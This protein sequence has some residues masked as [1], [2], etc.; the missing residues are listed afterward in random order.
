MTTTTF[1]PTLE[2]LNVRTVPSSGL[3]APPSGMATAQVSPLPSHPYQGNG[4]GQYILSGTVAATKFQLSGRLKLTGFGEFL[5]DGWVQ[6][7]G[8]NEGGRATGRLTLTDYKGT[9]TIEL[10]SGVRPAYSAIPP[11]LVYSIV[12]GTGA[13]AN[14]RGY[15]I[16]GFSFAPAPTA[17]GLHPGG[18]YSLKFS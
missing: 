3:T 1:R 5:A 16:A 11:E 12:G 7:P 9:M 2:E 8:S 13:Y 18:T 6:G 15:G 10:H 14:A 4:E 17:V